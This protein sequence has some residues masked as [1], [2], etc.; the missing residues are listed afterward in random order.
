ML[1]KN[2]KAGG[3]ML[4]DFKLYYKATVIQEYG[5]GMKTNILING[6]EYRAQNKRMLIWLIY[7]KGLKNT[8][9]R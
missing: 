8:Q 6:T 7:N 3:S 5:I 2:E 9:G 4:P 1:R